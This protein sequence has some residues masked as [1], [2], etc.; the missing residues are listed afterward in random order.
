MSRFATD[1]ELAYWLQGYF[2]IAGTTALSEGQALHILRAANA[3]ERDKRGPVA[4]FIIETL[5]THNDLRQAGRV[6]AAK[7]NE[8]FIHVIDPTIPGDQK[9]NRQAHDGDK[10]SPPGAV[11]MC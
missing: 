5:V 2:E 4:T 11:A 6:L 10:P 7:L 9:R 8:T 3:V 1:R